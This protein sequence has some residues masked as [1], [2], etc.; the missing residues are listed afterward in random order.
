ME[1][2]DG[3]TQG[4]NLL[5]RVAGRQAL[6]VLDAVSADLEPGT[7]SVLEGSDVVR[8]AT[9][10]TTTA[11]EGNVGELLATAAFLGDLPSFCYGLRLSDEYAEFDANRVFDLHLI[12]A[13]EPAE[14]ISAQVLQGLRKPTDCPAFAMRCTPDNPLG[15]LMV[16]SEGACAAYYRYRRHA[17]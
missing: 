15:A 3:G 8:F 4:L 9:G 13:D 6:V 5:R 7:V 10:S 16:S 17:S 1:F 12:I 14:C 11:H 2:V